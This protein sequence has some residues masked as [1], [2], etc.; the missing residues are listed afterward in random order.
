[1][2]DPRYKEVRDFLSALYKKALLEWDLDGFKLDFID[3][4]RADPGKLLKRTQ[5]SSAVRKSE[6]L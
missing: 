1:M 4:W 5:R 3:E 2:L 6:N